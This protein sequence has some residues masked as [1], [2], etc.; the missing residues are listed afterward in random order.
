[1]GAKKLRFITYFIEFLLLPDFNNILKYDT[2]IFA[3]KIN[4][5]HTCEGG[6]KKLRLPYVKKNNL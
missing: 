3:T 5:Q 6:A 4:S 1:M 2:L